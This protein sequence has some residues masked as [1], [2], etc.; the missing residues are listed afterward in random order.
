MLS[1]RKAKKLGGRHTKHI[2]TDFPLRILRD[3]F[4]P[5][6]PI[7]CGSAVF[8]DFD[9]SFYHVS[10]S[11]TLT[12]QAH[13]PAASACAKEMHKCLLG[14]TFTSR[15]ETRGIVVSSRQVHTRFKIDA[16]HAF[17]LPLGMQQ[18]QLIAMR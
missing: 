5:L 1:R 17:I 9:P 12:F 2:L 4:I 7:F 8:F 15:T 14:T 13:R 16:D 11:R 6:L 10:N 3:P 18:E